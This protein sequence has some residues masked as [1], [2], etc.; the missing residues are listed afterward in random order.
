[1]TPGDDSREIAFWLD[2]A[3]LT[4]EDFD[5]AEKSGDAEK[6]RA[7]LKVLVSVSCRYKPWEDQRAAATAA[8]IDERLRKYYPDPEA[9]RAYRATPHS[10]LWAPGGYA[11]LAQQTA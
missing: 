11:E 2:A 4:L 8:L 1:M 7:V 6:I 5:D 3:V 10:P 9:R